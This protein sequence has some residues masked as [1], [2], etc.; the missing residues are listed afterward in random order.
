LSDADL[1]FDANGVST[2]QKS[3]HSD[4]SQSPDSEPCDIVTV[5][6]VWWCPTIA[7]A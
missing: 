5:E 4:R 6:V 1:D 7:Q 3:S 2:L